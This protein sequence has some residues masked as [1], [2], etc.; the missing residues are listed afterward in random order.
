MERQVQCPFQG[1]DLYP[2]CDPQGQK[3]PASLDPAFFGRSCKLAPRRGIIPPRPLPVPHFVASL[4][5][6]DFTFTRSEGSV[7]DWDLLVHGMFYYRILYNIYAPVILVCGPTSHFPISLLAVP[8]ETCS[9]GKATADGSS[10][11]LGP[12]RATRTCRV[13]SAWLRERGHRD[14][15]VV[16]IIE[17]KEGNDRR[18]PKSSHSYF[19]FC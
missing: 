2:S 16:P 17:E 18:T 12:S 9:V 14:L 5:K 15:W 7:Y 6:T 3:T 13:E 8:V 4:R 11:R 1:S 19:V 10:L